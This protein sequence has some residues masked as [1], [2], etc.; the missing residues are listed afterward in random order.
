[1][2]PQDV[3]LFGEGY[4]SYKARMLHELCDEVSDHDGVY[5]QECSS[6]EEED[7]TGRFM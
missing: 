3:A 5:S 2:D 7:P 6:D 4:A 1:V